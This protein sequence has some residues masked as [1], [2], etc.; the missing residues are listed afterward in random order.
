[1]I[2]T[3]VVCQGPP[4]C[5]NEGDVAIAAA[6]A[7]CRWCRRIHT[8]DDGSEWTEGPPLIDEAKPQ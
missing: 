5:M 8:E 2:S 6:E 3:V 4:R 7:G 1:M